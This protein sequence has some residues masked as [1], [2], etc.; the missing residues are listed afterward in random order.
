MT[1]R[2]VYGECIYPLL[3]VRVAIGGHGNEASDWVKIVG[4]FTWG[5][6]EGFPFIEDTARRREVVPSRLHQDRQCTVA[7]EARLLI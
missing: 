2:W 4:F 5:V 1:C 3:F 6:E 7:T